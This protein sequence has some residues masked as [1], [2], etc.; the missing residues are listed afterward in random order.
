VNLNNPSVQGPNTERYGPA[1][2]NPYRPLLR[3]VVIN[4]AQSPP[5]SVKHCVVV[6]KHARAAFLVIPPTGVTAYRIRYGR[7]VQDM[8]NATEGSGGL[9]TFVI[10][11]SV[12]VT[13]ADD[14]V[15][16]VVFETFT[17]PVI[18]YV[19]DLTGAPDPSTTF[20]LFYRGA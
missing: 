4:A 8:S 12:D 2:A 16:E 1:T 15:K 17:D 18:A 9:N 19:D 14:P 7:W 11:G 5:V 6:G 10:T 20:Q 3:D 13:V